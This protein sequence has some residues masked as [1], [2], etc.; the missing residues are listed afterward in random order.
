V[1]SKVRDDSNKVIEEAT[2]EMTDSPLANDRHDSKLMAELRI[3][4]EQLTK[5]MYESLLDP[6]D[7]LNVLLKKLQLY[8]EIEASL[9]EPSNKLIVAFMKIAVENR[10]MITQIKRDMDDQVAQ[11]IKRIDL[12]EKLEKEEEE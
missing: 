6:D 7:M 1:R 12:L 9:N 4:D 8:D 10:I 3:K 2:T 5:E 11:I